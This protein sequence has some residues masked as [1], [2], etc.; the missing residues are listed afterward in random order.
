MS[1]LTEDQ[2]D[3][4]FKKFK[5]EREAELRD[6][7]A[8]QK[9]AAK[10]TV[11]GMARDKLS[12]QE[13][14]FR[15]KED[16]EG[17]KPGGLSQGYI[18]T[19]KETGKTFILKHV[20][21]SSKDVPAGDRQDQDN[22][23]RQDGVR[24]LLGSTMYQL[25]LYD[26]APK[27]GLVIPDGQ[28]PNHF[29]V[30][31]KFFTN[32]TIPTKPTTLSEFSGVPPPENYLNSTS[33]L[34]ALEGFEKVNAACDLLGEAD[35]H[36]GNLMV[37]DGR[38]IT[39]IDHGKSFILAYKDFGSMARSK[40]AMFE[41]CGYT[42]AIKDGNFSFSVE[43]YSQAINQ[44][45]DQYDEQQMEAIID[46]RFDELEKAGFDPRDTAV[47]P[48]GSEER[49]VNSFDELKQCYKDQMRSR[50]TIMRDIAKSTEIISK[51]SN[52]PPEFMNGG[53]LE[54]IA[55]SEIQDPVAY[56]AHYDIQIEGQ[57]ALEWAYNNNYK[58]K[59][60]AQHTK[61][62]TTEERWQQDADNKW[63]KE[64]SVI[65]RDSIGTESLDPIE[66]IT[67]TKQQNGLTL[68]QSEEE[69]L[70]K[71]TVL[72]LTDS[73]GRS[74]TSISSSYGFVPN[75]NTTARMHAQDQANA[76]AILNLIDSY[77]EELTKVVT[78]EKVI[79]FYDGLL[80][81]MQKQG[82]FTKQDVDNIKKDPNYAKQAAE[83]VQLL[84]AETSKLDL[85]ATD[86]MYYKMA[87][88][89]KEIGL[90]SIS[91]HLM[92]KIPPEKLSK[93]HVVEEVLFNSIKIDKSKST[94]QTKSLEKVGS[95][96]QEKL[97][98]RTGRW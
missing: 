16:K 43:K 51:F 56:A 7:K 5:E 83:T 8:P 89:T 94:V 68:S 76:D 37:Q 22:L 18:A 98:R 2:E 92:R 57:N 72:N 61:E 66:Y 26:R 48:V 27:E 54:A 39:K 60:P 34:Q 65:T 63:H 71:A 24:E 46:K 23:D 30:R 9:E 79:Q 86:K 19:E 52:M 74:L 82:Y 73:S 90:S 15:R 36:A 4:L 58:I 44:M 81:N 6:L 33:T 25:L 45:L 95:Y 91:D 20:Y 59:T 40:Y 64:K 49:R 35:Y 1:K 38:T 41:T 88:F 11:F 84:K 53:W 42:Q 69:F 67:R 32:E 97:E 47:F 62:T 13:G 87:Q 80:S 31:S 75:Q 93:V 3:E 78:T 14:N 85:K 77:T 96:I 28:D 21:K 29:Y 70:V 50:I 10:K 55:M 12:A 17:E